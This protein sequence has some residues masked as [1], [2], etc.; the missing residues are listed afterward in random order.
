MIELCLA[1]IVIISIG[2]MLFECFRNKRFKTLLIYILCI[3]ICGGIGGIYFLVQPKIQQKSALNTCNKNTLGQPQ[4]GTS[5]Q[6][7]ESKTIL[8]EDA[9][10][11]DGSQHCSQLQF[12]IDL[13]QYNKSAKQLKKNVIN[14]QDQSGVVSILDNLS[15][16]YIQNGLMEVDVDFV[17]LD[18]SQEEPVRLHVRGKYTFSESDFTLL[19]K[20]LF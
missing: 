12:T 8:F 14:I 6:V 7:G 13:I 11:L 5:Y 9:F 4:Y 3:A 10:Y 2:F 18:T 16:V 1:G 20:R 15:S 19:E 17:I